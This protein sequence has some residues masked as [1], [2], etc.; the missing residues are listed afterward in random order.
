ML[1]VSD[2]DEVFVPLRS[3]L[4]VK[5]AERR[6]AIE[7][8]LVALPE[9]FAQLTYVE[10]ALGSALRACLATLVSVLRYT[11]LSLKFTCFHSL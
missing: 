5:P 4:F 2:I 8:L 9:R 7:G 3:G 10:A 11:H 6:T 1:V